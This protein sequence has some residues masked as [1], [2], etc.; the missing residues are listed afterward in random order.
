M[1]RHWKRPANMPGCPN[2]DPIDRR[3]R[4][5]A[6]R[7]LLLTASNLSRSANFMGPSKA[8]KRGQTRPS[9]AT[10]DAR[11]EKSLKHG[12]FGSTMFV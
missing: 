10:I 12:N 8:V 1:P 6:A 4:R 11:Q 5:L 2:G 9:E 3:R 7:S